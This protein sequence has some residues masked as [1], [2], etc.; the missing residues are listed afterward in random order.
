MYCA[1]RAGHLGGAGDEA[2]VAKP[3][4]PRLRSGERGLRALADQPGL[5]LDNDEH[6]TAGTFVVVLLW[7]YYSARVFLLGA[8]FTH[9]WL[10]LEGSRQAAPI[11][12][13]SPAPRSCTGP[14][15][16]PG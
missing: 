16:E 6:G 5:E 14:K 10:G 4:L 12:P 3:H 15:R 2:R 11:G 1:G 9:A 8:E 13:G 7:A